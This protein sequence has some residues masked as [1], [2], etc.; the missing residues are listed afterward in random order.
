M[1]KTILKS[2]GAIFSGFLVGAIL[3]VGMDFLLDYFDIMSMQ[4]FKTN[5]SLIVLI[6]VLYRFVFNI[7]GSYIT[8]KL[9]PNHPM[10]HAIILGI[11]GTVMCIMGAFAMWEQATPWYNIAILLIAFPSAWIG[12]KLYIYKTNK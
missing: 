9:A 10:K 2:I 11:I 3:S 1:N 4:N 12:G 5:S 8:A 7:T 6:V